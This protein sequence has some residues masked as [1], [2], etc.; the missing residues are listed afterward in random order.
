MIDSHLSGHVEVT[1]ESLWGRLGITLEAL[2]SYFGVALG[3]LWAYKGDF[4][5]KSNRL[6]VLSNAMPTIPCD[7]DTE[8][9]G[10]K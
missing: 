3:S 6:K 9:E 4:E 2:S 1:L 5:A 7:A 10:M 8:P